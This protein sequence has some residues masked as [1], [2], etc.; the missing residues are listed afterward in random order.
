VQVSNYQD[1]KNFYQECADLVIDFCD[2]NNI[3]KHIKYGTQKKD[4]RKTEKILRGFD[5]DKK[6]SLYNATQAQL[7]I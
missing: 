2:R 6:I 4:D 1:N 3:D 5:V 7:K